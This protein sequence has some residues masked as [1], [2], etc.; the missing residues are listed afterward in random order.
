MGWK[1]VGLPEIDSLDFVSEIGV[2]R[3]NI[4]YVGTREGKLYKITSPGGQAL[5][6]EI[7]GTNFPDSAYISGVSVNQLNSDEILVCFSNY[8]IP[9]IFYSSDGG[10]SWTDVSGNLEENADG[11]GN[12]PSVRSNRII[13]DGDRYFVGTSAGLYSTNSLVTPVVWTQEDPNGI[14]NVVVEHV[15]ERVQDGLV[16]VGTHGNGAYTARFE[17]ASL[18]DNDLAITGISSPLTGALTQTETITATIFNSGNQP[19]TGFSVSFNI[20]GTDIAEETINTSLASNQTLEYTFSTTYDFSEIAD[21]TITISLT[22]TGDININNNIFTTTVSSLLLPDAIIIDSLPYVENFENNSHRWT[23]S[24]PIWELGEPNQINLN[25]ASKGSRAWMTDLDANYPDDAFSFLITPVFNFSDLPTP[26]ISFDINYD[27]EEGFDRLRLLYSINNAGFN[28]IPFEVGVENWYNFGFFAWSGSSEGNYVRAVADLNFLPNKSNVQFAFILASDDFINREGVALDA[29][30]IS[31]GINQSPTDIILSNNIIAQ[32][33]AIG[34]RIGMLSTID[35]NNPN[36]THTYTLSG[37][38]AASFQIQGNELQSAEIF[39]FVTKSTY[40]IT[41][42]TTDACDSSYSENFSINIGNITAIADNP[43][44]QNNIL[45]YPNPATNSLKIS[46][47]KNLRDVK[48]YFVNTIGQV[49][50]TYNTPQLEYDVSDLPSGTYVAVI[51]KDNKRK[52]I[53]FFIN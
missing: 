34:T 8:S 38:D 19:Q 52:M 10:T 7:T 27:L 3:S 2:S 46:G 1:T 45:L 47:L 9:S 12:G 35:A 21:Y 32:G 18:H 13:G 22:H 24:D 17:V 29:F 41:I 40:Q 16:G 6:T 49:V 26:H 48:I 51:L 36:D 11:T 5:A 28:T 31:T 37:V 4:V 15:I 23:T 53:T 20:D 50:K 25:S 30:K 43:L 14:G 33:H 42:T 39:N 44:S